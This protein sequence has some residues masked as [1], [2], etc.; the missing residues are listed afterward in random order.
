MVPQVPDSGQREAETLG[1]E[2]AAQP[3]DE[4]GLLHA[5]GISW[6]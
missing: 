1:P 5:M 6:I 4:A 3:S 2:R